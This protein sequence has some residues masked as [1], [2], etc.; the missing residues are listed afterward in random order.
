MRPLSR[1][2]FLNLTGLAGLG[3]VLRPAVR[4]QQDVPAGWSTVDGI[5]RRIVPPKFPARD[6][7]I[8]K[9][10]AKTDG[11]TDATRAIRDAIT[12]CSKAGGGRVV[13]PDGVFV[14]GAVHL[15]SGVNLHLAD[16]ATLKFV[17]TPD[18]Y[19]PV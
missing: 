15:Q 4:A 3:V 18:A 14:T 1:R 19:L 2:D 9:Y 16:R 13:I 11:T 5:V 17:R 10:G 7:D 12:A 6:F 8:T